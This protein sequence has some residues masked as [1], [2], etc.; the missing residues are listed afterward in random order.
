MFER[1]QPFPNALE[2]CAVGV[3]VGFEGLD[4]AGLA[5]VDLLERSL[6]CFELGFPCPFGLVIDIAEVGGEQF[7]ALRSEDALREEGGDAVEEGVLSY[8]HRRGMVGA[9]PLGRG[10]EVE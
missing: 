3:V 7:R 10:A 5:T 2:H 8:P 9:V 6:P 4:E 1:T